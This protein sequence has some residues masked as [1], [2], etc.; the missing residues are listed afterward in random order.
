VLVINSKLH[1]RSAGEHVCSAC[2][3]VASAKAR[4]CQCGSSLV[5]NCR[6][7][8]AEFP[9][10]HTLCDSCGRPVAIEPESP[11]GHALREKEAI[12]QLNSDDGNLVGCAFFTLNRITVSSAGTDAMINFLSKGKIPYSSHFEYLHYEAMQILPKLGARGMAILAEFAR[13]GEFKIVC[14][15]IARLGKDCGEAGVPYLL[16]AITHQIR[17]KKHLE[18]VW[19]DYLSRCGSAAV[20]ILIEFLSSDRYHG[21]A[22]QVSRAFISIGAPALSSLKKL[23]GFFADSTIKSRAL[24]VISKMK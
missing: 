6:W 18:G 5:K 14:A 2:G 1:I 15:A 7:C 22:D 4:F 20:P 8:K 12:Q 13:S 11:E 9:A 23:T 3:R 17:S 10:D 19:F 24:D 21:F 16:E